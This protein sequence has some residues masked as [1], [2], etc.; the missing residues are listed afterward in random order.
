MPTTRKFD[1]IL[2]YL[3]GTFCRTIPA[4]SPKEEEEEEKNKQ[5]EMLSFRVFKNTYISVSGYAD[6]EEGKEDGAVKKK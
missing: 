4:S 6:S 2:T 3:L 1:F 5:R